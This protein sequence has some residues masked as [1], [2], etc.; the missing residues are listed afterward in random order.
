MQETGEFTALRQRIIAEL[1]RRVEK[2]LPICVDDACFEAP[3]AGG[4][5]L[6]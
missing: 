4:G 5:T 2:G 1:M 3:F 6:E